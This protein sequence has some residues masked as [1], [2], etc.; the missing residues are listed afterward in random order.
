M[1]VMKLPSG[2]WRGPGY[3]PARN[4]NLSG[5]ALFG[6]EGT[7]A[8]RSE[9]Q[10]ARERARERLGDVRA[11]DLTL[12]GFWERWTTDPLFARPKEST[13]IHNRERTRAFVE[14]YGTR[15]MDAIDDAVVANWLA[16]GKRIGTIPAL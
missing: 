14:H 11:R 1:S 10:R 7:F 15:P 5:S 9:A 8:T 16:G 3:D 13:N 6:G 12:Y 4:R 2:R